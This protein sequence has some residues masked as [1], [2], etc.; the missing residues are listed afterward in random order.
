V[1]FGR[2]LALFGVFLVLLAAVLFFDAR[3]KK[4]AAGKEKEGRLVDLASADLV[5]MSL[6]AGDAV[7]TF[8]RDAKGEWKITEPLETGADAAEVGGLADGF[9]GL[10]IERVVAT[11]PAD[12]SAYGIPDK[13]MSLWVNGKDKPVRILVG[14]ENPIDKTLFAKRDDD[15]RVV[16]IA[17]SLKTTLDKKLFDFRRK[18]VFAFEKAGVSAVKVRTGSASWEASKKDGSWFLKSPLAA[19]AEI[20]RVETLLDSLAGLRAKEFVSEKRTDEDV[21]KNGLDKPDYEVVLSMP[22]ANREATMALHKDGDRISAMSSLADNIVLVERTILADLDKKP[23][24]YREKKV[25][26]FDSWEVD[27]LSVTAG[28]L[29]LAVV[30]EKVGDADKWLLGSEGKTEADGSKVEMFIRKIEGLEAAE[31]I[32]IPKSLAE[33]G[34]DKPRAEVKIRTKD[35]EGKVRE[36]TVLVG[37]EDKDKKQVVVKNAAFDYLFRVDSSFLQDIPKDVKDWKAAPET[38]PGDAKKAP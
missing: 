25:A 22:G 32:D 3:G 35:Y 1:K 27:R 4:R 18:D 23:D 9:S 16:L 37:T 6:K 2:T 10:R 21:R 28:G 38:K 11:A 5:K 17:S 14:I 24:E 7:L 19:L 15:P 26:V 13:E 30:K 31:F 36:S 8:E 20:S 12:L 33:Y 34:L 29:S